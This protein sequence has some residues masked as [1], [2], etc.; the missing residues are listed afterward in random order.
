VKALHNG[1]V[2]QG[3]VPRF[4][5]ARLGSV[6][7]TD[8]ES[9]EVDASLEAVPA[10]LYDALVVPGGREAIKMLGNLG[11]AGEFVKEQYRHCKPILVLGAG[12]DLVENAGVPLTLSTGERDPGVLQFPDGHVEEALAKFIDAIAKHRHFDREMDPPRV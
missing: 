12:Q 1:L 10:V 3:A 4:V 8:G 7:S 5:G 9:I 2:A 6:E 11:H